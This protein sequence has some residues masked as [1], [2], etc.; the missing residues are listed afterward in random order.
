MICKVLDC[1][2]SVGEIEVIE[3]LELGI[4]SF[5]KI[6][7][8]QATEAPESITSFFGQFILVTK[9]TYS[10]HN[11]TQQKESAFAEVAS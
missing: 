9:N 4:N 10:P 5:L 6:G 1:Y 2:S 3:A 8:K 7:D 11:N